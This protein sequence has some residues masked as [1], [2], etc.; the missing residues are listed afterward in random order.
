MKRCPRPER[1]WR[2]GRR[3]PRLAIALA[4][5]AGER[6][7]SAGWI[8]DFVVSVRK[9]TKNLTRWCL[10]LTAFW[11]FV[12]W[13]ATSG[14]GGFWR[15]AGFPLVFAWGAFGRFEEFDVFSF[16]V[17]CLLGVIV[18]V[19]TV[20]KRHFGRRNERIFSENRVLKQSLG[21]SWLC[22]RSRKSETHTSV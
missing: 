21:L 12:N 19:E 11:A 16:V 18:V 6:S 22:A 14:L 10:A 8:S 7:R 17:D 2:A 13:P 3:R 20:S 4:D 9:I 5:A 15:H 1:L